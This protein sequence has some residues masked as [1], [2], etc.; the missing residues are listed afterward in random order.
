MVRKLLLFLVSVL[1]WTSCNNDDDKDV[2]AVE[3][4]QISV[5]AYLVAENNLD[6]ELKVNIQAM[7]DGLSRL[8]KTATLLIYWDGRTGIAGNVF[9]VIMRYETD[10]KGNINGT[11]IKDKEY[12]ME[13]ILTLAEIVKEYPDQVSTNKE[14]MAQVLTDMT[15]LSPTNRVGLVAGS[16]ATSWIKSQSRGRAFGDDSGNSINISEMAEAMSR[17]GRTFDFLLFDACL[18][19][20]AE[21]CYDFRDVTNYQ[22][23]SVLEIPA[24]GFPYDLMIGNLFEGTRDGYKQA[25]HKYIEYYG[26]RAEQGISNSWGTISLIDSHKM[27]VLSQALKNQ[28]ASHPEQLANFDVSVL[29][30]YG[31]RYEFKYIS[32]D[33][34]QFVKE[35]NGGTVPQEFMA[36]LDEA[37]VYTDCLNI[38][39]SNASNYVVD[40]NN[41]CGLGIYVPV[42]GKYEW[43]NFFKGIDWFSAAGWNNVSFDWYF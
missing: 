25:C 31:K 11:A 8:E 22:I 29:Q 32:V 16:H 19:G 35:L 7:F 17:T 24:D 9:P 40:K 2:P 42:K 27:E 15:T 18:M 28:L 14:V 13:E 43:N 6:D 36:A 3:A 12:S 37:V 4:A 39:S 33:T 10:G 20:S 1:L 26:I 23:V 21:V 30:E 38:A 34:R 5:L 41:Y